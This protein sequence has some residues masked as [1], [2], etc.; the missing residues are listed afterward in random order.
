[1]CLYARRM[2]IFLASSISALCG[3]D[4]FTPQPQAIYDYLCKFRRSTVREMLKTFAAVDRRE[5]ARAAV[6]TEASAETAVS[7]AINV[8]YDDGDI[9]EDLAAIAKP[10]DASNS[11]ESSAAPEDP[12]SSP[13]EPQADRVM[14]ALKAE[15]R[16]RERCMTDGNT[17]EVDAI[18]LLMAEGYDIRD[19]QEKCEKLFETEDKL[20]YK[21]VGRVDG[22]IYNNAERSSVLEIKYR[23]TQFP[24][25]PYKRDIDQICIYSMLTGLPAVLVELLKTTG[26]TRR[27]SFWTADGASKPHF[28]VTADELWSELKPEL[29]EVARK[30]TRLCGNPESKEAGELLKSIDFIQL[31][32]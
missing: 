23:M 7:K 1:M 15:V 24:F 30:I 21:V 20:A 27:Q 12:E 10:I 5:K 19:R 14:I 6:Q 22:V 11:T 13:A 4:R 8:V 16:E 3:R 31:E 28:P 9:A 26:E 25:R 29:D 2:L 17:G 32:K 18:A